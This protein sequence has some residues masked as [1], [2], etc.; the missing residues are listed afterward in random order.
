MM[1]VDVVCG[2]GCVGVVLTMWCAV[3]RC[4]L[5]VVYV[6]LVVLHCVVMRCD[7]VC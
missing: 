5:C 2:V 1:C 7:D 4:V 3:L 6:V